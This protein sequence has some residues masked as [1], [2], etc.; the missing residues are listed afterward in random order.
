MFILFSIFAAANF[1]YVVIAKV[2]SSGFVNSSRSRYALFLITTALVGCTF[3][4]VLSGFKITMNR[5]TLIYALFC[6]VI[7]ISHLISS[8]LIYRFAKISTV[9][10]MTSS[11]GMITAATVGRIVFS[12][13]IT[14]RIII[15]IA[16][17][18]ASVAFVYVNAKRTTEEKTPDKSGRALKKR[19]VIAFIIVLIFIVSANQGSATLLKFFGR[20]ENVTDERSLFFVSNLIMI[21]VGLSMLTYEIVKNKEKPRELV[22]MFTWKNLVCWVGST[23][24]ANTI[25]IVGVSILAMMEI[26]IYTTVTAAFGVIISVVASLIFREKLG[27]FAYIAAA[28]ACIAVMI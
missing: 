2:N 24:C 15:K 16:V 17:M 3:L 23:V 11:L 7:N 18:L 5:T 14:T 13:P 27:V 20:S 4:F 22:K 19:S 28:L 10:I 6:A 12:E 9:N 21:L 26:G 25:S 8:A 1:F